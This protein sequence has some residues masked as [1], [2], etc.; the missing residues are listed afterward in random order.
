[1]T[2]RKD[3]RNFGVG[4]EA[5]KSDHGIE[6][7]AVGRFSVTLPERVFLALL[8]FEVSRLADPANVTELRRFFSHFF[9]PMISETERDAYVE[10]FQREPPVTVLGYPRTGAEFP[11]LAV[12]LERDNESDEALSSYLGQS[13]E[14]EPGPTAQFR[15]S[16]WEK[17]YG[18]YVYATHPDVCL[19]TYHF[20]KMVLLGSGETLL[21]CG[22]IDPH[23]EGGEMAPQEDLLPENM[24][25]RRLG[26]TCKSLETVPD[27]L[28]P[29]PANV[30]VTG[31]TANNAVVS[32]V[33]GGIA[34]CPPKD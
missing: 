33:L 16:M 25:V 14:G 6:G 5:A 34:P 23:Y 15:G 11:C 29:D 2:G 9:D 19:Y 18:I 4:T 22:I 27:I 3:P 30:R 32:G 26:V 20:A 10:A 24:F 1:M 28:S 21:A 12:I 8:R 31:I 13:A 17:T 7:F